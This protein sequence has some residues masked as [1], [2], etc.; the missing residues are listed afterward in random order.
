LLFDTDASSTE[1]ADHERS[2]LAVVSSAP[3]CLVGSWRAVNGDHHIANGNSTA[4]W[5]A[6]SDAVPA[7]MLACVR[8]APTHQK[9]TVKP[10]IWTIVTHNGVNLSGYLPAWAGGDPSEPSCPANRLE[11]HLED[12]T[13]WAPFDGQPVPLCAPGEP[14]MGP[15][16][17]EENLFNGS[18]ACRPYSSNPAERVPL[19]NIAVVQDHVIE[20]LDPNGVAG[21][22]AKLRAQADRLDQV[23]Q[24]L[25]DAHADWAANTKVTA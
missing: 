24:Q 4:P 5:G 14:G 7:D 12:L 19:V 15:D 10:R 23:A 8:D 25:A 13:H 2:A 3:A 20:N 1:S 9:P 6:P 21:I 11:L 17:Y 18:I 22:A 16:R